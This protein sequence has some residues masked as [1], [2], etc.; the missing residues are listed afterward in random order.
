MTCPFGIALKRT[1][2]SMLHPVDPYAA[3]QALWTA[4][5]RID[6]AAMGLKQDE[7]SV[8]AVALEDAGEPGRF[9]EHYADY[10]QVQ[11]RAVQVGG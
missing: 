5:M 1:F 4:L 7:Q 9:K 8:R 2:A 10:P 6:P 3:T 11:A